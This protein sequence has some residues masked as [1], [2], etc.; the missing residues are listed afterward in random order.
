MNTGIDLLC[1]R[2]RAR[3][4][5]H[6]RTHTHTHTHIFARARTHTHTPSWCRVKVTSGHKVSLGESRA[7]S[8]T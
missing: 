3:A 2:A 5:T 7:Q 8:V 4:H 6:F 1:A